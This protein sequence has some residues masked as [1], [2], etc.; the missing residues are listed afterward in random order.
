MRRAYGDARGEA[1]VEPS[2]TF[3][4][5]GFGAGAT[6]PPPG[7]KEPFPIDR[8]AGIK[9]RTEAEKPPAGRG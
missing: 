4:R 3:A 1:L 7:T 2:S 9:A 5:F 6:Y 8:P